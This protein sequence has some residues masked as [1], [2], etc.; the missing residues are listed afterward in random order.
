MGKKLETKLEDADRRLS[1][2]EHALTFARQRTEI[3]NEGQ[4]VPINTSSY[5]NDVAQAR[6]GQKIAQE[7]LYLWNRDIANPI[8]DY[9]SSY[10]IIFE[11]TKRMSVE[12]P[13]EAVEYISRVVELFNKYKDFYYV[14]GNSNTNKKEEEIMRY[15]MDLKPPKFHK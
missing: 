7:K 9:Y 4:R 13:K 2:A 6:A 5:E 8:N 11:Q 1:N 10:R 12:Y 3:N 14:Q 15:Y